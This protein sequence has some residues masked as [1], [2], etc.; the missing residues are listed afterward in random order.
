MDQQNTGGCVQTPLK[1]MTV[2]T[3]N[4]DIVLRQGMN[5]RYTIVYWISPDKKKKRTNRMPYLLG[6]HRSILHSGNSHA[7][8][9][10]IQS[11]YLLPFELEPKCYF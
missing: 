5:G 11:M 2:E 1:E 3:S 4:F 6:C 7:V 10:L 8:T 9:M